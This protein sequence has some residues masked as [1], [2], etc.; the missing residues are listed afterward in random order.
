[1]TPS[2]EQKSHWVCCPVC[3]MKTRTKVN[4]NT[5]L[6]NFPLYCPKCKHEIL[7]DVVN[8]KLVRSKEPDV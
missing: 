4:S 3:H 1:M 6:L 2:V 7:I 5:I 8:L